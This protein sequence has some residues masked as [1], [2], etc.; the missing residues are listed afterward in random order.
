MDIENEV[1]KSEFNSNLNILKIIFL[2]KY[3]H[4]HSNPLEVLHVSVPF[5]KSL[6][7]LAVSPFP[8]SLISIQKSWAFFTDANL[9]NFSE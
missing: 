9:L 3:T 1:L 4:T 6:S 2:Y 5:L 8:I 7:Q